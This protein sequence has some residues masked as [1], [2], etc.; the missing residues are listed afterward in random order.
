LSEERIDERWLRYGIVSALSI[1]YCWYLSRKFTPIKQRWHSLDPAAKS[2]DKADKRDPDG[3]AGIRLDIESNMP[4]SVSRKDK[5]HHRL[6]EFREWITLIVG[7]IGLLGLLYYAY[8]T[9]QMWKEMQRQTK[10]QRETGVNSERAWVGLDV[11]QDPERPIEIGLLKLG[12]P[13]FIAEVRYRV[14]NFG[15]GPAFNINSFSFMTTNPKEIFETAK[16]VCVLPMAFTEGRS[17]GA[18]PRGL[19]DPPRTGRML[20]PGGGY[21]QWIPDG[22]KGAFFG[23]TVPNAKFV[24]FSGCITYRDQFGRS[25]WS[26]WSIVTP[27]VPGVNPPKLDKTTPLQFYPF[28]NDSDESQ[29]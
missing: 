7:V 15:F 22:T 17:Q 1:L 26:R 28:F 13:Q 12:P 18:L 9:S 4:T 27:P 23:P 5:P 20:F 29:N 21:D 25:H 2:E 16:T 24:F 8:T 11:G 6:K 19:P 14:K 3:S 10:I